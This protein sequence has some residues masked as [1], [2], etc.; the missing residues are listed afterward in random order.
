MAHHQA[1]HEIAKAL[2]LDR[3]GSSPDHFL[4]NRA[5]AFTHSDRGFIVVREQDAFQEKYQVHFDHS[6]ISARK[7]KFSQTAVKKAIAS[8]EVLLIEDVSEDPDLYLQESVIDLGSCSVLVAPLVT[9][10]EV[11]AVIYLEKQ[12]RGAPF[13]DESAQ[14][15]MEF[16]VLAAAAFQRALEREH[17]ARLK[18]IIEQDRTAGF[19]DG[20]TNGTAG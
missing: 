2:L 17:F 12:D 8:K 6:K 5:I 11:Y 13:N 20:G 14:F 3:C 19:N 4:L 16:S 18:H 7:R 15:M 1:L 9:Q 10:G